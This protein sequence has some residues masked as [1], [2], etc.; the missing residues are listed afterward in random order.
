[1]SV[2]EI[3]DRLANFEPTSLPVLSLY[4]NT[5]ADQHGRDNFASFIKKEFRTRAKTYPLRSPERESFERDA[6]RIRRYLGEELQPS[7]NGVAVFA[8]SGK[9]DFFAAVQLTAPI[10]EHRLYVYHQPHLYPLARLYDQY[11]RYAVLICDTN[12]ARLFVFGFGE[13]LDAGAVQNTK[14][15]RTSVGGWSQARYQRHVQNYHLH[16]A[17]EVVDVL[18]RTVREDDIQQ[19]I[20]A[21]DEVITPVLLGQLPEHLANRVIEVMKLDITTP[22]HQ[23]LAATLETLHEKDAQNDV[24]KVQQLFDQ[25]RAGGLGVMGVHDTMLA[26]SNGQVDELFVSAK[27][28][29]IHA[30][31]EEIGA[32]LVP[33]TP[34]LVQESNPETRR[35]LLADELV[36]RARQTGARVNFIEDTSLLSE[37]GGVGATL[38]FGL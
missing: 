26:L 15:S 1:M 18:D 35:V 25:Y 11:R 16:H 20:L 9:E 2:P 37:F 19:I 8:C 4:L 17:K 38:R 21:G 33:G 10:E 23:V 6:D 36:T 30:T 31:E 32:S 34:E 12:S 24:E 5:Q 13:R 3:L 27:L 7:T 22:E 28:E 29:E 14:V